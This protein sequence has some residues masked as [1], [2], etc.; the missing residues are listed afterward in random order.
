MASH[1][2]AK[3]WRNKFSNAEQAEAYARA[4]P[5]YPEAVFSCV[6]AYLEDSPRQTCLDL[7]T[8]SG[9]AAYAWANHFDRL[10]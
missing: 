3:E 10:Q 2:N 9:Q 5:G 8:G 7:A 6:L 4:R 1:S